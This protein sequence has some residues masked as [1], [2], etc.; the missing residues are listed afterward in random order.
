ME[1]TLTRTDILKLFPDDESFDLPGLGEFF[2][3]VNVTTPWEGAGM[4]RLDLRY[5]DEGLNPWN[6]AA[7]LIE[8][9]KQVQPNSPAT[10][11]PNFLQK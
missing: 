3:S 7:F 10:I 9:G 5:K 4:F 8:N 11:L 2:R 6:T 1:T